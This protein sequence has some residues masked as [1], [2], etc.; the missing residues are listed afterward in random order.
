M[1]N[2]NDQAAWEAKQSVIA[3]KYLKAYN[4]TA[5]EL[6]DCHDRAELGMECENFDTPEDALAG[7][8]NYLEA[9]LSAR[10]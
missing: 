4:L 2:N 1:W 10:R 5:Q 9:A 3:Q 8:E 6:Q 7:Y